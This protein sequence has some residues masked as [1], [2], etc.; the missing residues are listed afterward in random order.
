MV[1]YSF[2]FSF[3]FQDIYK[4]LQHAILEIKVYDDYL[5]KNR[6]NKKIDFFHKNVVLLLSIN[7]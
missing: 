4:I 7:R 1:I 3:K 6:K 2:D 5:F